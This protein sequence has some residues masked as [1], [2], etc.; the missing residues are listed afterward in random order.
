VD[1]EAVPL[2]RFAAAATLDAHLVK[3]RDEGRLPQN[4]AGL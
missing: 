2:L 3:L 4:N 1:F